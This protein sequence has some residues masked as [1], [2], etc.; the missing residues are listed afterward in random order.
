MLRSFSLRKAYAYLISALRFLLREV[1]CVSLIICGVA[2]TLIA[3]NFFYGPQTTL[4]RREFERH[5]SNF[6]L[7]GLDV[8]GSTSGSVTAHYAAPGPWL[9]CGGPIGDTDFYGH[10]AAEPESDSRQILSPREPI[11]T[12]MNW[13]TDWLLSDTSGPGRTVERQGFAASSRHDFCY[14]HGEGTYGKERSVCDE[15]YASDLWRICTAAYDGKNLPYKIQKKSIWTLF[16]SDREG[17]GTG[18]SGLWCPF[19]TFIVS[20][21]VAFGGKS[22]HDDNSQSPC[23][24]DSGFHAP[25]DHIFVVRTDWIHKGHPKNRVISVVA[26]DD[27]NLRFQLHPA[28]EV[29]RSHAAPKAFVIS[30]SNIEVLL[31]PKGTLRKNHDCK[32]TS[33]AL[34]THVRRV[35]DLLSYSPVTVDLDGDGSDEIVLVGTPSSEN[36]SVGP[37]FIPIRVD[38]RVRDQEH[39]PL[40]LRA[41]PMQAGKR[42][43]TVVHCWWKLAECKKNVEEGGIWEKEKLRKGF[44]QKPVI[45]EKYQLRLLEEALLHNFL[46]GTACLRPKGIVLPDNGPTCSKGDQLILASY[47]ADSATDERGETDSTEAGHMHIRTFSFVSDPKDGSFI[48]IRSYRGFFKS[49][50]C[51]HDP[52][53]CNDRRAQSALSIDSHRELYKRFQYPPA[54]VRSSDPGDVDKLHFFWRDK[55]DLHLRRINIREYILGLNGRR[56]SLG[57]IAGDSRENTTAV[58]TR[59]KFADWPQTNFPWLAVSSSGRFVD[60]TRALPGPDVHLV[61]LHLGNCVDWR[62]GHCGPSLESIHISTLIPHWG[63]E[64]RLP[65]VRGVQVTPHGLPYKLVL[66]DQ[67]GNPDGECDLV[68]GNKSQDIDHKNELV[69]C[70]Y[71]EKQD[72]RR[73]RRDWLEEYFRMPVV[74]ANFYDPYLFSLI[75][76]R[77]RNNLLKTNYGV[78]SKINKDDR[79]PVVGVE[80]LV[81][82]RSTLE[83]SEGDRAAGG[84]FAWSHKVVTCELPI[85]WQV[86]KWKF[87]RSTSVTVENAEDGDL[88]K[89]I[90]V[91]RDAKLEPSF[92][93]VTAKSEGVVGSQAVDRKGNSTKLPDCSARDDAGWS[94][95]RSRGSMH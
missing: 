23:E 42:D 83:P 40:A 53:K 44:I 74:G 93:F 10:D 70:K 15:D 1:L 7:A 49:E 38:H 4:E 90:F 33:A 87:L 76:M 12:S 79:A 29:G 81:L 46:K 54:L 56:G 95:V 52:H 19:Q 48:A 57:Y 24:Y 2:F 72:A 82:S 39:Y 73:V 5:R 21:G 37:F 55:H 6:T 11:R 75:L 31:P 3:L 62:P 22:Y 64:E 9:R 25:R 14:E 58:P 88:G 36:C 59:T 45:L 89:L 68:G 35:A 13:I 94:I 65:E 26:I 51:W 86:P 50:A 67:N 84:R 28:P 32:D 41:F 27:E 30:L 66:L 91:R 18:G 34:S 71:A 63:I 85:S 92:W 20:T 69:R 77:A 78:L 8:A 60:R 43:T 17:V 16:E 47:L 80:L 61:S